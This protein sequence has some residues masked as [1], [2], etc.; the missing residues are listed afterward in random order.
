VS[1]QSGDKAIYALD[2]HDLKSMVWAALVWLR[3]HQAEINALNV[4][5]VPDGDTGTNMTLT[6][7]SVW[8][9]IVDVQEDNI[10]RLAGKVAHGALMGARGN[11][12][13]I[14]SQIWRG[15]ARGLDSKARLRAADVAIAMHEAQETAYKGVVK[16]VEGTILTVVREVAEEAAV[17]V[18]ETEDLQRIFERMVQSAKASVARTPTLLPVLR[19]AG[20][21]D[22]GGQGLFV[23]LEGMWRSMVGLPIEEG[24]RESD[25]LEMAVEVQLAEMHDFTDEMVHF[26]SAYPYDV[27]FIVVGDAMPVEEV[28]AT[29][30]S[31]G[32]CPLV[33][34]DANTIKVHVHVLDPGVPISY[35]AQCGSL[36]DV[37]VED[38]HAQ[39]QEFVAAREEASEVPA[40]QFNVPVVFDEEPPNIGVVTVAAGEGLSRVLL[41]L[42]A[43]S[44]IEGGQTMNPSTAQI[45]HAIEASPSDQAIILPN[46]KNILM[47][48]RQAAEV[49][50]KRVAVVPTRTIPQGISALL[51]LDQ[52]ATLDGNVAAM[53]RAA[54]DVIT[55]EVTWATRDVELNG[56]DVREGDAIGL[57]DGELVVDAQS[58]DEV[59]H[60]LI[61]EADLEDREL[62]TL[63]YGEGVDE[64]Q[65][66]ALVEKLSEI[67]SEL[68]FEIVEGGQPHYPYI[69]SI[70]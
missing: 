4:F 61:A 45:L 60:W 14:L 52:Q 62:V 24:V 2:G 57:L 51:S 38:M 58:F 63:Y 17:V 39:Y 42:G 55:G 64:A 49:S 16:P 13:V 29:I 48:A 59:V 11:S 21:V 1:E 70:E 69:M 66:E 53:L 56:I 44:I 33:V 19:Q 65:T 5:P 9:E 3:K 8:N 40:R 20:V 36:R 41:S 37:V 47:A 22:S 30:E 15:F 12:G 10:G 31:M 27:Q 54:K 32:D 67:Y 68:E 43:T 7:T 50:E 28:R 34:G 6:M 46:N 35:G 26:D 23:V 25:A 18:E